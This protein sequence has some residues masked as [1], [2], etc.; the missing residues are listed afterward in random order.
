MVCPE[1][2]RWVPAL[3]L[4][5]AQL[6]ADPETS[7]AFPEKQPEAL[8]RPAF[9]PVCA[10]FQLGPFLRTGSRGF[11]W[12]EHVNFNSTSAAWG[13]KNRAQIVLFVAITRLT[14]Y[15]ICWFHL[16]GRCVSHQGQ[17]T[18]LSMTG[19]QVFCAAWAAHNPVSYSS[20]LLT[21]L[22]FFR[23]L[24]WG[25]YGKSVG[26]NRPQAIVCWPFS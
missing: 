9:P 10:A 22:F 14:S 13:Y 26:S 1:A 20:L 6:C 17:R 15:L 16:P 21:T 25:L 19:W 24:T 11:A 18:F 2:W 5:A 7:C 3:N 23:L 12:S 4:A 8:S